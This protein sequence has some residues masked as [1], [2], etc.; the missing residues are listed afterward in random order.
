MQYGK[1]ATTIF[2]NDG[3][4]YAYVFQLLKNQNDKEDA[5]L[6][7]NKAIKHI[8]ET[9]RLVSYLCTKGDLLYSMQQYDSAYAA[10]EN[11][12]AYAPN[13]ALTLNN[14]SYYLALQK[15]HLKKA[16]SMA[17]RLILVN[18]NT[19]E[20]LDT[21][22]WVLYQMQQ[23]KEAS[24]YLEKAASQRTDPDIFEHYGDVLY[25]LNRTQEALTWWK[26][27]AKL[28]PKAPSLTS[29][30]QKASEK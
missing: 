24:L 2:P 30:I 1:R 21:Y 28:N 13:D 9:N 3:E 25:A 19:P 18:P 12:L 17:K 5:L 26:K 14:Y 11:A 22:G 20:Y 7:L 23:Y 6:Y 27:A 29:K 15:T 4:F 8:D 16:K 10:F